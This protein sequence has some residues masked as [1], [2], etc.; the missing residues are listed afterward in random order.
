[1]MPVHKQL[2]SGAAA[3]LFAMSLAA[4]H[5]SDS[6][7]TPNGVP[8]SSGEFAAAEICTECGTVSSIQEVHAKGQ[9]SGVGAL[10]GAVIGG[11]VG[12]QFGNGKGNDAMTVAGAAGG[13]YAGLQAERQYNSTTSYRVMVSMEGGGT[14]TVNTANLNGAGVGSKVRV[15]GNSLQ[16][17]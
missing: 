3:A 5:G 1:M 17:I 16:M 14:R 10:A 6:P 9:G 8:K 4:C 12:H 2:I 15:N 13:A 7:N 11:V